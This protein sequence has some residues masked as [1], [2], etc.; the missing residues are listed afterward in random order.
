MFAC[1]PLHTLACVFNWVTASA[2]LH[3]ALVGNGTKS[4]GPRPSW[5]S[6]R[7]RALTA[8]L[9]SYPCTYLVLCDCSL[10]LEPRYVEPCRAQNYSVGIWPLSFIT[11]KLRSHCV[12]A[13]L[14]ACQLPLNVSRLGGRGC[15]GIS[16]SWFRT[17]A[18]AFNLYRIHRISRLVYI[19][20]RFEVPIP[21]YFP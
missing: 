18:F 1:L 12:C 8:L 15:S 2:T 11:C 17:A 13:Q 10:G 5:K 19:D 4:R 16:M 9:V 20:D 21:R 14:K 3:C 6:V 7:R